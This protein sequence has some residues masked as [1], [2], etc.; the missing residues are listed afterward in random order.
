MS[1]PERLL[2]LKEDDFKEI[3][4]L[5]SSVSVYERNQIYD[6][7]DSLYYLD[8]NLDEE[9]HLTEGRRD[10][11]LDALRAVLYY[12]HRRGLKL[13]KGNKVDDLQWVQQELFV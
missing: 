3:F 11:A 2:E 7:K 9:Y 10:F 13:T 4:A 12:L 6:S 5:F 8:Q 1:E